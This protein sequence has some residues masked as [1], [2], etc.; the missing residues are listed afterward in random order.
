M[1]VHIKKKVKFLDFNL[2]SEFSYNDKDA[3]YFLDSFETR[4]STLKKKNNLKRSLIS[5]SFFKNIF[6][7]RVLS[8]SG[9]LFKSNLDLNKNN[10]IA[11]DFLKNTPSI[12]FNNNTHMSSYKLLSLPLK[13]HYQEFFT[14]L[15]IKNQSLMP[16]AILILTTKKN[17]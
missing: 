6:G 15:L 1:Y 3:V 12:L 11:Q 2:R 13:P 8:G 4:E 5:K 16:K 7:K 10:L 9:S 17:L 14:V